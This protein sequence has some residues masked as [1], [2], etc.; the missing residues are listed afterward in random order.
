LSCGEAALTFRGGAATEY[1]SLL[2]RSAPDTKA[3][4]LGPL[5]SVSRKRSSGEEAAA[6]AGPAEGAAL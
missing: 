4:K 5:A 3:S 6:V 1:A 2:E